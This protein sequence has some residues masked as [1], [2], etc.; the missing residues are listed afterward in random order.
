M[1]MFSFKIGSQF[2]LISKRNWYNYSCRKYISSQAKEQ[3]IDGPWNIYSQKV[4]DGS[5]SKDSH[6]E[7]VVQRLQEVFQEVS[8]F[9]RPI[10]QPTMG[11]SLFSIFRKKEPIKVI[12]PKGLYIY[13]SVGGGKTMLMDLFY[14]TVPVSKCITVSLLFYSIY[15]F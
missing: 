14:E 2:S 15:L 11:E 3:P 5:L 1:K 8:D 12:A 6:Q 7:M 4:T 9:Q 10:I 13:G